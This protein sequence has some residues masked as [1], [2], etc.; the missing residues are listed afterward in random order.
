MK[1]LWLS[2]LPFVQ[3]GPRVFEHYAWQRPC[4]QET[5]TNWSEIQNLKNDR[6]QICCSTIQK[7]QKNVKVNVNMQPYVLMQS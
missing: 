3:K 2:V 6:H 4:F 7:D 1:C 5:S